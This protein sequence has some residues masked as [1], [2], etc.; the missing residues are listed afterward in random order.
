MFIGVCDYTGS[1]ID[2]FIG[3]PGRMHDSRVFR[4]SPLFHAMNAER[5]LISRN[6][7]LIGDSAYPLLCNLMTPFRDN[8]HLTRSQLTYNIK[9]S[10]IRSIIERSFGLLKSKFRRLKYL[11]ISDFDLG[12]QMIAA[13][14]V[15]HNFIIKGDGLNVQDEDYLD[16]EVDAEI[17]LNNVVYEEIV[18]AVEKR[19]QIVERL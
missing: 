11:D 15:L 3:M 1:F 18:E 2:C 5:P 17:Q 13:A 19:R 16:D 14:C 12:M 4:M 8:G 6:Q 7:H 10:S 9:L